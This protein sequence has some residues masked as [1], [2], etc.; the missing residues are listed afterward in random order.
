[1]IFL[2]SPYK[3][4]NVLV[5]AFNLCDRPTDR[6]RSDSDLLGSW[7][8]DL[9]A[10][11]DVLYGLVHRAR[12]Q[13]IDIYHVSIS[14][15]IIS[16]IIIIIVSSSSSSARTLNRA[17]AQVL[18]SNIPARLEQEP[19]PARPARAEAARDARELGTGDV[20]EHDD[21][22]ACGER[23]VCFGLRADLDVEQEGEAAGGAGALDGG[24]Y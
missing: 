21:V 20:V 2:C 11:V 1:M 6:R 10:E 17:L 12:A 5:L 23:L 3:K 8:L 18:L 15:S 13:Y 16:L 14:I 4:Q 22:C 24:G 9:E 19:A 7:H